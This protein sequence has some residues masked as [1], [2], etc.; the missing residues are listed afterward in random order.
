MPRQ[1]PARA[2]LAYAAESLEEAWEPL[3]RRMQATEGLQRMLAAWLAAAEAM[4]RETQLAERIEGLRLLAFGADDDEDP[5]PRIYAFVH[6]DA[7]EVAQAHAE[8]LE[9]PALEGSES[10]ELAVEPWELTL[11]APLNLRY[12]TLACW[13]APHAGGHGLVTAR[14]AVPSNGQ[15]TLNDGSLQHVLWHAPNCL[16]ATVVSAPSGRTLSTLP[17]TVP[18]ARDPVEVV[19]K[20]GTRSGRIHSVGPTY[21]TTTA[22]IPHVFLLDRPLRSGDSGSLVRHAGSGEALGIYIGSLA[23]RQGAR[24]FCQGLHQLDRLF[25]ANGLSSG[26]HTE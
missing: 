24:G 26:F 9:V 5:T 8:P 17:C 4:V 12:G 22:A 14:H 21:G 3:V 20:G 19:A 23:T 7:V 15:L 2:L 10:I 11:H 25:A 13:V 1:P 18:L 6:P 16:D